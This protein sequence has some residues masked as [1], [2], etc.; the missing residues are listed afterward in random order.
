MNGVLAQQQWKV[1]LVAGVLTAILGGIVLA[2]PGPSILVAATLFGA[3]LLVSG[4]AEVFLAFTLPR[5]AAARVMWFISGALSVVLAILSFRHFGEGYA[6]LLLS[7]WIGVSFAFLGV[8]EI[9]VASSLPALPGRAWSIVVGVISVIAGGVVVAW[10]FDSIVVLAIVSG[11]WLV[12]IGVMQIVQAFQIRKDV[13][14]VR[15][16]LD[17]VSQPVAA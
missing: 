1:K 8:S 16:T 4:F 14:A 3:Y 9:A 7:V 15:Q 13:K 12:L 5:S 17:A 11:V 2:W 10:P 6:V